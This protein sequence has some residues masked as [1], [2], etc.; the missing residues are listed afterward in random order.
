MLLETN[1]IHYLV[2][3]VTL[4]GALDSEITF[5]LNKMNITYTLDSYFV[6][7]FGCGLVLLFLIAVG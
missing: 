5:E 1:I 4:C 7:T 6:G 3:G 2:I